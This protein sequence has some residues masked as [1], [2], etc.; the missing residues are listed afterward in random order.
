MKY[1]ALICDVDGTLV[2]NS[3][4]GIPSLKVLE[5]LKMAQQIVS[6]S[7]ATARTYSAVTPLLNLLQLSSP[8]IIT[9]GAQIINP[10]TH[11]IF[12]E[13]LLS[14]SAFEEI[15]KI[16]YKF[17]VGLT[18]ADDGHELVVSNTYKPYKPQD[19][20]THPISLPRA[21]VFIK[22]ISHITAVAI[23]VTTAWGEE[24]NFH[25]TMS[26]PEATKH[27]GVLEVA[28][29]LKIQTSEI[30]GIGE[31]YNDLPLLMACGLKIAMGNAVEEVKA[32]ADY[33]APS[34]EHDGVA[35]VI[36]KF[37]LMT[38]E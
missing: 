12:S 35:D 17:G 6:V 25:V 13:K 4:I 1:K 16:A 21:H 9:G 26:H 3:P 22:K 31:G 38:S 20:Y 33:I 10:K 19:V 18:V 14:Q 37:I 7:I 2:P 11:E 24:N 30:I 36:E 27:Y 5:A 32:I 28:K 8:C 34:V 29:I 23:H 15:K